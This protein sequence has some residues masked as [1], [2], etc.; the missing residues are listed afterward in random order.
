MKHFNRNALKGTALAVL[1]APGA[2]MA[3]S[4][5]YVS[6]ITGAVDWAEV[7]SGVGTVAA[8]LAGVYVAVKGARMLLGMV[9]R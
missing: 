7:V 4:S 1:I 5:G 3:D 2:A 6:E 8:A 9:R